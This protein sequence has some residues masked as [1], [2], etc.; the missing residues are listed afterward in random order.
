M[1]DQRKLG[2]YSVRCHVH[3]RVP[4]MTCVTQSRGFNLFYTHPC[5][6]VPAQPR[7]YNP[8]R[9]GLWLGLG[10]VLAYNWLVLD[11]SRAGF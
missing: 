9:P 2:E 8:T 11:Y 3:C 6:V 10:L 5:W 7:T 1:G 4:G